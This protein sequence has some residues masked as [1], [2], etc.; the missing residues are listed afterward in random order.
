M[1]NKYIRDPETSAI[2]E[3]N[4][5]A[6]RQARIRRKIIKEKDNQINNLYS[7]VQDLKDQLNGLV[8]K[9]NG[10]IENGITGK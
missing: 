4:T 1:D 10:I 9:I 5:E 8:K 7:E 2:M 3:S 6:L